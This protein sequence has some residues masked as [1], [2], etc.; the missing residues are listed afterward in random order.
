MLKTTFYP[1]NILYFVDRASRY[2]LLLITEF[3]A[4]F[5]ALIYFI[6]LHVSS[7]TVLIIRRSN[8]INSS[9]GM[10]NLCEWLLGTPDHQIGYQQEFHRMYLCYVWLTKYLY[11]PKQYAA[12]DRCNGDAVWDS[13]AVGSW[14]IL[15]RPDNQ[16]PLRC[17]W[18]PQKKRTVAPLE[19]FVGT[20]RVDTCWPMALRTWGASKNHALRSCIKLISHTEGFFFHSD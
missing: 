14:K 19:L 3:I 18:Q 12:T 13:R 6:S 20:K 7:I 2:E 15:Y 11:S 4:L 10:M 17:V 16:W 1:Q 5:H 9:P 8:R